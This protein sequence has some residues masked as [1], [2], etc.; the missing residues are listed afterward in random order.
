[1]YERTLVDKIARRVASF[2]LL[3]ALFGLVSSVITFFGYELRVLRWIDLWGPFVAW[4]IRLGLIVVGIGVYFVVGMLDKGDSPDVIR[5]NEAEEREA[6]ARAWEAMKR[7]PRVAQL[8]ADAAQGLR[9]TWEPSADPETYVVRAFIWQDAQY[10]PYVDGVGRPYGPDDP[11]VTNVVACLERPT[12][13]QRI[14]LGQ[15][16]ATRA[17][18]TQEAHPGTWHA[19]VGT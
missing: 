11:Q 7:H 9:I 5:A 14:V 18:T 10:R 2:G 1:M 17:I 16:L 19:F 15:D 13:P 4:G 8:L 3:I 12:P 6:R